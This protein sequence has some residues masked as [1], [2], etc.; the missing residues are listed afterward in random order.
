MAGTPISNL[1]LAGAAAPQG[2][3]A[4][5]GAM[6]T[7]LNQ[8]AQMAKNQQLLDQLTLL[9]ETQPERIA[10]QRAIETQRG[11]TGHREPHSVITKA[12]LEAAAERRVENQ[13]LYEDA[14]KSV[15]GLYKELGVPITDDLISS[16]EFRSDVELEFQGI[17]DSEEGQA[18]MKDAHDR[19]L[20][21][22]AG[23]PENF[24]VMQR[25][26]IQNIMTPHQ[27]SLSLADAKTATT[28]ALAKAKQGSKGIDEQARL[29]RAKITAWRGTMNQLSSE[30]AS[31]QPGDIT[32]KGAKGRK[33]LVENIN[34]QLGMVNTFPDSSAGRMARLEADVFRDNMITL[35]PALEDQLIEVEQ[36]TPQRPVKPHQQQIPA[37]RAVIPPQSTKA[38]VGAPD[39]PTPKIVAAQKAANDVLKSL[40]A[41]KRQVNDFQLETMLLRRLPE[42][43][44]YSK[45]DIDN[46]VKVIKSNIKK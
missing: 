17:Y 35:R 38:Q 39:K 22:V 9:Q 37:D 12:Q 43:I 30:I 10:A 18:R 6:G 24:D 31:M 3:D 15:T 23:S 19:G 45:S 28:L 32:G 13:S 40:V 46:L 27:E 36:P 1:Q 33:E 5:L 21:K 14:E 20:S 41:D 4:A 42:E 7:A 29:E 16:K 2:I 26:S 44:E 11:F 25:G 34:R 8:Q